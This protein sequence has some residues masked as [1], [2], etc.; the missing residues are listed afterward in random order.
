MFAKE[1]IS[2]DVTVKQLE[3]VGVTRLGNCRNHCVISSEINIHRINTK[4]KS[5]Q[6]YEAATDMHKDCASLCHMIQMLWYNITPI[7]LRKQE[8][9]SKSWEKLWLC[10]HRLLTKKIQGNF[11]TLWLICKIFFVAAKW[12]LEQ[13]QSVFLKK[14]SVP[15]CFTLKD[16]CRVEIDSL[17]Q[18]R[19]SHVLKR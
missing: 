7:F 16:F 17:L 14:K 5:R 15:K 10:S 3:R 13:K 18:S 11:C 8:K 9:F 1:V 19:R 6:V 12:S 2:K 4:R